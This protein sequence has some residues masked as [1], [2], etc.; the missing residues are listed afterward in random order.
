LEVSYVNEGGKNEKDNLWPDVDPSG[1]ECGGRRLFQTS[2]S[3]S[4]STSTKAGTSTNA[5]T[6]TKA[7]TV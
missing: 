7:H 5:S 4:P 2:A 3:S 1:G 6:S